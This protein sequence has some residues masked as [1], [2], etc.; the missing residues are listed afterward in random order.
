L[1]WELRFRPPLSRR[2]HGPGLLLVIPKEYEEAESKNETLDPIPLHKWAEEGYAVAQVVF[3][4]SDFS[5]AGKRALDALIQLNECDVKDQ[6]GL[7]CESLI[8]SIF[9]L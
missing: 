5:A 4:E 2:G 1:V 3:D 7:I 6:I 8:H 9:C